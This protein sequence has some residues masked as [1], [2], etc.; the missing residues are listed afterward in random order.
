MTDTTP[1]WGTCG[2]FPKNCPLDHGGSGLRPN[3]SIGSG[4]AKLITKGLSKI[5][6]QLVDRST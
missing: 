2:Q 1:V 6:D 3:C 4:I 5:E